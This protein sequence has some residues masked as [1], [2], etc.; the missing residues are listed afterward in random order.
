MSENLALEYLI[1]RLRLNP[2]MQIRQHSF[3]H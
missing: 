3:Q 1:V 2:D